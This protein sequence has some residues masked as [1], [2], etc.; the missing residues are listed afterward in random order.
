MRVRIRLFARLRDLAGASELDRE[1]PA[2]AT[3]GDVWRELAAEFPALRAYEATVSSARNDD[4][5]RPTTPVAD[6]DEIAF[7]PPV[8]GGSSPARCAAGR[9]DRAP[10]ARSGRRAPGNPADSCG[11]AF[12]PGNRV[13]RA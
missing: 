10:L 5:A 8:S 12:A 1:V 2:G 6:G 4:Y 9:A 13:C 7:L 3:I 11:P